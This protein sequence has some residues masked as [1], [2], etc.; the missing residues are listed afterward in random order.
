MHD[1]GPARRGRGE[2]LSTHAD[3]CPA[4][5]ATATLVN[6]A[7]ITTIPATFVDPV[8]ANN[9]A[10]DTDTVPRRRT[11][12][13]T[14][15]D[16]TDPENPGASFNY[17]LTVNNAGPSTA[18][19]LTVS[20]TVPAQYTVNT[21]TSPTGSCGNVGNVVTCTLASMASGAPAWVIT[22]NVTV[23]ASTP[24]GTY[25]NTATVSASSPNDPVLANN[26]VN[27][28][29]TVRNTADLAVTKTDGVATV[30]VGASTTY[31]ITLTNNGPTV[32]PA[33]VIVSDTIPVNTVGSETEA[34]CAITAGVFRCTTTAPLAVGAVNTYQLTLTLSAGFATATLVN[35]ASITTIP[36]TFVDPVAA[37]NTATDTDTVPQANLSI[38]KTDS[39]D[40]ENPGASFNYVL[41]V[42][43]AGPSTATNLTVSDTVPSQYTVNTVTSPTGSCGN[44]GNVVTCT[45]ASMASGAPA[46]VI[47][48]NVTVNAS[49]PGGTYVNTATVSA[50]SPNDPV[51]ANNTVNNNNTVRNTADLAV[52][53]TDGV[54]TVNVGASTTYTITLTNNGPTVVPAGVIV[55]DT[56]PVNTVGSETEADC[57]ITAGVFRCTTSAPLAVG[58]VNTYQLTLT[59]SAGFATATLVN[60]A[61]ITTI[62]AT[63]V[64]PVAANNT[65]TDTDT[66]PQ[67]N[68]SITKTDSTDPENP[69]ASFNYVLTVNNAGPS[70]ATNLTVSD[71]V[72]SQYTVN[73]VTSP[74]G[75]C[76]NVGNVVTCTLAS[77]ASGAPAW[78]I[79]VNVTVNASTPGGT[80]VN[81]ATVSASSPNDPV[82]ANN[83]VNNNNTV[84]NT[85]DLAVTKTDGVAT[86]IAGT[87]TT[88][89]ITITNNGPST[90][91]PGVQFTDTIPAGTVGSEA[92]ADCVIVA[93]DFTCTTVAMIA[94]GA[95]Q[96]YQLT[97][98]V[99]SGFAP[100]MLA[101][102]ANITVQSIVDPDLTNNSTTDT[103]GVILQGDLGL[104]KSDGVNSVTAGTST[105][106]TITATNTGPSQIPAGAVLSDT[107]PVGTVGS[108]S[109][110]DCSISGG[111]FTCITS[112]PLAVGIPVIVSADIGRGTGIRAAH[113]REHRLHL[114]VAGDRYQSRQQQRDRH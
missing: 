103:D 81:T 26:T 98:A 12:S 59:L 44:V 45:L 13:I 38:T 11:S 108:E 93:G 80:Y 2:H 69:G 102:T 43:N 23:N 3:L 60:T 67:A 32:V 24:G 51:L 18:T 14:K 16:S 40:P 48:V 111:A 114:L 15:T 101:N 35:T 36:A 71:T 52:T 63:F 34:D 110:P 91:P 104:A 83:T 72:P 78:V 86:V 33:G 27:N 57:A 55:S 17:V 89:T 84:R 77:M 50:S 46:W 19:N 75:S 106:Y 28:N 113:A 105:T 64:D 31:T 94:V 7:S 95:S 49:T 70:T 62:P 79:T 61:S 8:A 87:S 47:T 74:T 73:T 20:D 96:S 99:P 97:L 4:G 21:V 1:D 37:N 29:N 5:F 66:V 41:T 65:A 42:N 90:E 6:T 54:A 82:L 39:T 9:T 58:A 88:Y 109:E 53:K 25:V 10:T 76:G 68:L 100:A 112:A 85:A 92:E 30:N 56:I 22:V 107:I